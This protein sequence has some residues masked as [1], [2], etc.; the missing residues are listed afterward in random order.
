MNR[1]I[2]RTLLGDDYELIAKELLVTKE[3]KQLRNRSKNQRN[4]HGKN[5][6]I[7]RYYAFYTDFLKWDKN[8]F[9]SMCDI[10]TSHGRLC[11]E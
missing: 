9:A 5:N 1:L 2:G 8:M 6:V 10:I 3:V 11:S 7:R 4:N